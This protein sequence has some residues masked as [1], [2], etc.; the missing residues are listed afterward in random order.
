MRSRPAKFKGWIKRAAG[1]QRCAMAAM[2]AHVEFCQE[3]GGLVG[4]R[5]EEV[6]V[7]SIM[8]CS[9]VCIP[10]RRAFYNLPAWAR[11]VARMHGYRAPSTR[12]TS[13]AANRTCLSCGRVYAT[14]MRLKRHL[15]NSAACIRSW[16][17]FVP[18]DIRCPEVHT[19]A[20]PVPATGAIDV[21]FEGHQDVTVCAALRAALDAAPLQA[22]SFVLLEVVAQFHEP[23]AVLRRTV[24]QWRDTLHPES[25]LY[26][27]SEDLLLTMYPEHLADSAQPFC[28]PKQLWREE[29]P[30]F[31]QL[32]G[33]SFCCSGP[34]HLFALTEPPSPEPTFPWAVFHTLKAA[35]RRAEWAIA[36]LH[37]CAQ[38]VRAAQAAPTRLRFGAAAQAALPQA[39]TWLRDLGF[40]FR[41]GFCVSPVV[42]QN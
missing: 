22:S 3:I 18:H 5:A 28:K 20:P 29:P 17:S 42:S 10:C 35:R 36:A 26:E 7:P 30:T 25:P 31:R 8:D 27:P 33:L 11:H 4:E 13:G 1:L 15:D 38:A 37:T 24:A 40:V 12:L 16:G 39:V 41:E 23:I 14:P 21:D 9:E 34:P 19:Q 32:S 6:R 2:A